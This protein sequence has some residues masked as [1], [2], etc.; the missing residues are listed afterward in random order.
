MTKTYLKYRTR[1]T[2]L[3]CFILI[4]WTGLC[5]RLFQIQILNGDRYQKTVIKQA[6]KKQDVLSVR[7]NIFDR[8][9]RPLTR[10]II[11]YTLSVNP[12]KILDKNALANDISNRTGEPKEKYLKKLNS[13]NQFEYLERN[14]HRE[15][16]GSLVESSYEGLYIEKKYRR[17]YPH[18]Q[19]AAQLLGYTNLDDEGI[20][21]IEKDYNSYLKGVSGW[22]YKTKG[23][24]GIIQH[25]SG[26]PYQR[27]INGNNIQLTIDLEYQSILEQELL[28]RQIDTGAISATGIIM[29]PETGEI[30]AMATTPGFN[31]NEFS[32][33]KAEL[34]RIKSITDQFEPGSTFK[35]VSAISAL[36][37]Q[38]INIENEF[39]CENGFYQ[40]HTIPIKDHGN[41][42][43]GHGM[44]NLPQIIQ[45]SS[46]IGI[47]KIIEEVGPKSLYTTSRDFGFGSK[48]GINLDGEIP[49][50]LNQFT[51]WSSVSLGQIA[52]G[53]EVGVTALQI[54]NAYCAIANGG[55]L[56]KP[57]IIK[58]IVDEDNNIIYSENPIIV[59]KIS[60]EQ[61]MKDLR[62]MLR[63]VITNGTGRK[64]DITG[65]KVAGKTGTA[66]KWNK[67][68]YSNNKFISNFIGFF[69]YEKPQLLA[70]I[71]L[72]EP[73]KPY[74]WG[75]EGA[76]I[77]FQRVMGRIINMDDNLIPPISN[78]QD[79]ILDEKYKTFAF[80]NDIDIQKEKEITPIELSTYSRFSKKTRVPEIRGLSIRKALRRLEESGLKFKL[81]GKGKIYWQNPKPGILVD[82]GTICTIGLKS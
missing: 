26:M 38:L 4:S 60:N 33:T 67:G 16:L 9:G 21:G 46:N 20:S 28:K 7:G 59:R 35:V 78:S 71:M 41:D 82:K 40:Y 68:K 6:Q 72:D 45:Y 49:G 18:N 27:P 57:R 13:N 58:Q 63:S 23:T 55:Y 69:P 29:D 70:F 12:A 19:I 79:P 5:A 39:N 51:D 22:V 50:K 11:H 62:K 17:Y 80:K 75:N 65:W 44:L 34:H 32:S 42:G 77:A 8:N 25:K 76:A 15:T 30:I 66:Q 36:S 1:I 53:H 48:T 74:H 24:S 31:N 52:M 64:A 73:K 10:N 37:N 54:A 61:T 56:L 43:E 47:I 81:Q 14:L 3:A 2:F